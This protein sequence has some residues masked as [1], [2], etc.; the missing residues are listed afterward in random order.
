MTPAEYIDEIVVP[1]ILEFKACRRS[2]RYAYL[3]CITTFHIKDHL[4]VAGAT[5][6]ETA[7]RAEV[8]SA[9]DVVRAICN[10]TKHV[11]TDSSHSIP[12]RVGDDT[13]R[14]PAIWGEMVWDVSHWD[15]EDGGREVSVGENRVDIYECVRAVV[16]AFK[17]R[18][19]T[20]LGSCDLS[21]LDSEP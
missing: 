8:S 13:D 17:A 10:G 7:I 18:F 15:D 16:A 5:G 19:S 3:A 11:E 20:Y 4:K 12:F 1:T 6:I 21:V 9:F 14:P 2:R